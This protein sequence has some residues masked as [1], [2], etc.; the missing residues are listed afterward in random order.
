M[1]QNTSAR[2]VFGLKLGVTIG[3]VLYLLGKVDLA[4]VLTQ[5]RSMQ[6]VQ[7]AIALGAIFFQLA[8]ISARWQLVNRLI[9]ARMPFG[10]V[11]RLTLV[12]Q[13]FNQILPSALGGDAVRAWLAS[14]EGIPL[15][16][17]VTGIL[18]D[19][20]VALL[21]LV[22]IISCTFLV[23]PR[24][25]ADDAPASQIFRA[26]ALIGSL[27]LAGLF[28]FGNFLARALMRYRVTEIAGKLVRDLR[29]VLYSSVESIYIVGLSATVQFLLVV[30]IYFCATGMRIDLGFVP[31]LLVVPAVMLVSVIPIS[32]GGWG[33]RE[34]AM[35]FGLGLLGIAAA[36]ALAVSVAY[37]LMQTVA[38]VPGGALWLARTGRVER[39]R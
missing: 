38:G 26:M 12:G 34:G 4:P 31:A 17:A 33:V 24:V 8:L 23:L 1:N 35:V 29:K 9:G 27:G 10:L 37:G 2:I 22:L 15:G 3:L 25:I 28:V 36:D 20:A 13:F 7:A 19:R 32:Y 5:I 21:V 30:A 6:S 16:R 14:R 11:F 39:A 18:C